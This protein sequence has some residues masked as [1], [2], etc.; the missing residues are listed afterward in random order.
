M[1]TNEA[2]NG[3]NPFDVSDGPTGVSAVNAAAGANY[4]GS[5]LRLGVGVADG[6]DD[7][8]GAGETLTIKIGT[9]LTTKALAVSQRFELRPLISTTLPLSQS[10]RGVSGSVQ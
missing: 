6:G 1:Y 2:W 3:T 7:T 9:G 8:I 4:V 5:R 10:R